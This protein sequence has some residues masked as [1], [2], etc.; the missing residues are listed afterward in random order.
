MKTPIW[1]VAALFS[2]LSTAQSQENV[3]ATAPATEPPAVAE[4]STT[5]SE[6]DGYRAM[7]ITAGVIGGAVLAAILTD[8]LIIPAYAYL[9]GAEV[10]AAGAGAAAGAGRLGMQGGGTA[11]HAGTQFF[12]GSMRLLGAVSGGLYA[13]SKYTASNP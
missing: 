2:V 13:D 5:A 11:H 4:T 1:I 8:G 10:G 9:T 7:A 12:R 6:F 3:A